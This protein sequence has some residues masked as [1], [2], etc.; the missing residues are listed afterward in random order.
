MNSPLNVKAQVS[1]NTIYGNIET[2]LYLMNLTINA[3]D[4]KALHIHVKHLCGVVY[5]Y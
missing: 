1:M 5:M 4:L 2:I 3:C